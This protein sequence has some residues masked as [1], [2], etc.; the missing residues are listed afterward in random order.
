MSG[1]DGDGL[2]GYELNFRFMKKFL[3]FFKFL[4][5]LTLDQ[6]GRMGLRST[7]RP[8]LKELRG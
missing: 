2:V 8:V 1:I 5:F 6:C 7:H 4:I 3:I